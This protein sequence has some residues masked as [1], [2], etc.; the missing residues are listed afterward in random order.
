MIVLGCDPGKTTGLAVLD[1]DERR[2]LWCGETTDVRASVGD[3]SGCIVGR[4]DVMPDA[5]AYECVQS[6][7]VGLASSLV[8]TAEIGGWIRLQLGAEPI[9]RPE[10]IRTLGLSGRGISKSAV[11]AELVRMLGSDK[12]GKL[13]R[14]RNRKNH[15]AGPTDEPCPL[16]KGSGYERQEGPLSMFRGKPHARDALAVAVAY[17][18]KIGVWD[19]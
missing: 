9:S 18:I 5:Y 12:P 19:G 14:Y 7:G 6:Y 13:C 3:A 16:C 17:A 11:W 1:T 10:V 4:R 8:D 2:V 15:D